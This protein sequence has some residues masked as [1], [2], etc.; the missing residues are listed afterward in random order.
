MLKMHQ[1]TVFGGRGPARVALK[2][3]SPPSRNMGFTSKAVILNLFI[4]TGHF[5]DWTSSL[6]PKGK[7]SEFKKSKMNILVIKV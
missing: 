5:C 3:P 1:K 6:G 4:S 7:N 2:L